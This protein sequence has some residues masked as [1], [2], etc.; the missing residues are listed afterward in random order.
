[1]SGGDL[2]EQEHK[3]A[4]HEE[5]PVARPETVPVGRVKLAKEA[6]TK[7]VELNEDVRKPENRH[8][9]S[10]RH[11]PAAPLTTPRALSDS[12]DV[13]YT[14]TKPSSAGGEPVCVGG[15]TPDD[16]VAGQPRHGIAGHQEVGSGRNVLMPPYAP[17]T[18]PVPAGRSTACSGAPQDPDH[19][20]S[21][22][23]PVPGPAGPG[24]MEDFSD[25]THERRRLFAEL[26]G[27]FLLV[28][29]AAGGAVVG[30]QSG[31][32]GKSGAAVA[33]GLVVMAVILSLGKI[34]GAHLNPVVTVAF[35]VR[36]DFQWRRVPGYLAAQTA[37]G[38][39]AC[40]L[41]RATFG[42][43]GDLGATRPH[44]GFTTTQ[45]LIT[46]IVLTLGLVSTILGTA[47]TA[48]NVGALAAIGVGGYIALAGLWAGPVADASMNPVRSLAP[49]VVRGELAGTWPY[50]LGPLIG[51]AL[52]VAFAHILRGPGGDPKAR[53]AAQGTP[54][55]QED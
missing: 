53:A 41:L 25:L 44:A 5:R 48:Q 55:G 46:E 43:G 33:P 31:T 4:L 23:D 7:N 51:A 6:T 2:I 37:G 26:F 3:A 16:G 32:P 40:A 17:G 28:L 27:T 50:L 35:A 42:P 30:A 18:A 21:R 8:R 9:Q 19:D 13:A 54:K 10:R 29:V 22:D 14:G 15:Q 36:R 52:A 24:W 12:Q 49:D 39:A 38:I 45:A 47:S 20:S 34:S 1:M 11:P